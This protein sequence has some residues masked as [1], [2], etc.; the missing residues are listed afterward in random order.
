MRKDAA[1][2]DLLGPWKLSFIS[3]QQAVVQLLIHVPSCILFGAAEREMNVK[4]SESDYIGSKKGSI[5]SGGLMRPKQGCFLH[6]YFSWIG[7][8]QSSMHQNAAVQSTTVCTLPVR[9]NMPDKL[10]HSLLL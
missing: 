10:Q 8:L 3:R 4:F 2:C 6:A 9:V 5:S 7:E 1:G